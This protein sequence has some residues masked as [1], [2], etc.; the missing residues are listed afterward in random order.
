[1]CG[2]GSGEE[3]RVHVENGGDGRW[4]TMEIASEAF[5]YLSN[6]LCKEEIEEEEEEEEGEEEEEEKF[7]EGS[8]G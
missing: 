8:C 7:G 3:S 6:A 2:G 4:R 1:M 5:R